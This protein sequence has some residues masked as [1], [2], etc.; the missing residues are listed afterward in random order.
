MDVTVKTLCEFN[1]AD[2]YKQILIHNY[3]LKLFK[4]NENCD[5]QI[6]K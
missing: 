4:K 2:L 5:A 1:N 3:Y 6:L